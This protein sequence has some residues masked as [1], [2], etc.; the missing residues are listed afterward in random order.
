[1]IK[2]DF[3]FF[4]GGGLKQPTGKG[5]DQ[6][7]LV[8]L[9]KEAGY[10]VVNPYEEIDALNDNSGKTIAINPVFDDKSNAALDFTID[11]QAGGRFPF[12]KLRT[13]GD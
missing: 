7:D 5:K 9:A 13:K 2:S 1:M 4:G 6:T 12:V 3:E 11:Q 10:N 8:E